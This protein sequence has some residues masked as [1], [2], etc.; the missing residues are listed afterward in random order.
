MHKKKPLL[1]GV[2]HAFAAAASVLGAFALWEA[3]AGD[4]AKQITMLVFGMSLVALYASSSMYHIGQWKGRAY[5]VFRRLDHA[6]IFVLIAGTYTPFCF[7]VLEGRT[8][9]VM[10]ALAWSVAAVGVSLKLFY[11][12]LT[13]RFSVSIYTG[14]C[15]IYNFYMY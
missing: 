3:S 4:R 2:S 6:M 5:M 1:R 11:P 15:L 7:N 8:R 13:R 12:F 14:S 9:V 10:L